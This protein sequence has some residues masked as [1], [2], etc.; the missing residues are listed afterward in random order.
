MGFRRVALDTTPLVQVEGRGTAAL[1]WGDVKG[2]IVKVAPTLRTSERSSF[3]AALVQA[4]LM[5][6]GALAV[7]LAPKT[8][9]DVVA[10]EDAKQAGRAPAPEEA[11]QAWFAGLRGVNEQDRADAESLALELLS[12]EREG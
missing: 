3:D 2:A 12:I 4:Q 6:Q 8:I 7:Q 10:P 11:I 1:Q 5:E 9:P